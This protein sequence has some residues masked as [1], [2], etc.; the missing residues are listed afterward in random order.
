MIGDELKRITGKASMRDQGTVRYLTGGLGEAIK[1]FDQSVRSG[2]PR[3]QPKGSVTLT[4]WH[5]VFAEVCTTLTSGGRSVA[6]I[7]SR[8]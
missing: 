3:L 8:A 2:K 4:T 7:R 6:V 5:P 1:T